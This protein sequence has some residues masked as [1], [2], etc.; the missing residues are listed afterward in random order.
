MSSRSRKRKKAMVICDGCQLEMQLDSYQ[1]HRINC[2]SFVPSTKEEQHDF[3]AHCSSEDDID[4]TSSGCSSNELDSDTSYSV[5]FRVMPV[6][7]SL[8]TV[9]QTLTL[10][11][12]I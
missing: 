4:H 3:R 9:M 8:M 12:L 5:I 11:K 1:R 6:M 2:Q 7:N 10:M